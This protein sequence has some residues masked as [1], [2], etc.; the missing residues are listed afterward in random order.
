MLWRILL[1]AGVLG[2]GVL[3]GTGVVGGRDDADLAPV[4]GGCCEAG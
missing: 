3:G 1:W 2:R 4:G